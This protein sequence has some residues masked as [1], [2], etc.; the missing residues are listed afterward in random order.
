MTRANIKIPVSDFLPAF[1]NFIFNK[2]QTLWN[3]EPETSKLKQIKPNVALWET[4]L[5]KDRRTEVML[6]RLR[7]G[8][9]RLTHG[10]LM[11]SPH[12]P[13]PECPQCKTTLSV[14]HFLSECPIFNQ[15]RISCF[16]NKNLKEIL[17]ESSSF[18][19][20]SIIRFLKSC[21]LLE[22]I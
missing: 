13:I 5:Q 3:E 17:S 7:I 10:Y 9:T 20:H 4:S 19:V 18:S 6:T 22:K 14:K 15:Q 1:K 8:H 11:N 12:D 16:G 21:N 2:W